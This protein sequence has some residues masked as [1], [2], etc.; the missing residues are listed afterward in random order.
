MYGYIYK[1][2]N[3]INNKIY[4]GQHRAQQFESN[5]YIGSGVKLAKAIKKYGKENFKCELIEECFSLEELNEKEI[6][7][8][9]K[10]NSQFE[11]YNLNAGGEGMNSPS[12]ETREK[13]QRAKLGKKQPESQKRKRKESLKKVIHTKEWVQ[14]IKNSRQG[15]KMP[16]TCLENS[17]K[18]LKG[19]FWYNN[20]VEEFRFFPGEIPQGWV[21]GRLKNPFPNPKEVSRD[22]SVLIEKSVKVTKNTKW[23][24][25]GVIEIRFKID[26]IIPEGFKLGRLKIK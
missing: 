20:G 6:F 11:G 9:Q 22:Y 18:S 26:S 12:K 3:L 14:K 13:M 1:T 24:N 25:N 10:F 8:I 7:W 23:Y 2:T 4:I 15:A 19:T 16:P 21:K 17:I 5:K